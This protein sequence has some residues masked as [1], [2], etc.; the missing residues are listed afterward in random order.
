MRKTIQ[1][2]GLA[3]AV[4]A[5]FVFGSVQ[6]AD[7][8]SRHH[9]RGEYDTVT[10]TYVVVEGDDRVT[11]SER[12]EIPIDDLKAQNQLNSNE[13]KPGQKLIVATAGGPGSPPAKPYKM[14]TPIP[15]S[16]PM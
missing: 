4:L 13:I 1:Q 14:T 6:A 15:A 2:Y 3:L 7:K 9:A 16:I 12:F 5:C 11:I 8:G 10:A